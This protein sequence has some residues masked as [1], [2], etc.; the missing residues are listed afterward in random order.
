VFGLVFSG[1]R[2]R[3]LGLRLCRRT[4]KRSAQEPHSTAGP[5]HG[6]A[7][8]GTADLARARAQPKVIVHLGQFLQLQSKCRFRKMAQVLSLISSSS[9]GRPRQGKDDTYALLRTVMSV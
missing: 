7:H 4:P 1:V 6:S 9:H 2:W 3:S 8:R 5:S